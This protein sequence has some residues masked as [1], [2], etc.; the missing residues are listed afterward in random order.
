MARSRKST[1]A[2]ATSPGYTS[3]SCSATDNDRSP[4]PNCETSC[5]TWRR[6]NNSHDAK[7]QP[8]MANS[9]L[10]LADLAGD[11]SLDEH[12]EPITCTLTV[13]PDGTAIVRC[14]PVTLTPD[15]MWLLERAEA[16]D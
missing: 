13:E 3:G 9:L 8:A 16:H 15:N 10:T 14:P 12:T 1:T 2:L 6:T 7:G 4:S 5:S 11:L